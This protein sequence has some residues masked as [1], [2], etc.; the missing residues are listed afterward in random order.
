MF[1]FDPAKSAA[2]LDKHGIDFEEVQAV[3]ADTRCLEIPGPTRGEDKVAAHRQDRC[4]H[5]TVDLTR[6]GRASRLISA[7]RRGKRRW[8]SMKP[9]GS[10]EFDRAFRCRRGHHAPSRL[11][12]ATRPNLDRPPRQRRLP[13]LDGRRPRRPRRPPRHHPPGPDQDVDRGAAGVIVG[14]C[15]LEWRRCAARIDGYWPHDRHCWRRSK[16]VRGQPWK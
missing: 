9:I 14:I 7:R 12:R 4:R 10:A 1:E 6:R 2:N 3:W 8:R 15:F 16:T 13:R 11:D 5:W